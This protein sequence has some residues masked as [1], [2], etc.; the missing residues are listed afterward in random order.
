AL[1]LGQLVGRT[2]GL[3]IQQQ[4]NVN[5][6]QTPSG[7]GSLTELQQAVRLLVGGPRQP[8]DVTPVARDNG[9]AEEPMPPDDE[10]AGDED[11]DLPDAPDA[12]GQ[13]FPAEEPPPLD[14]D[15][16]LDV[17]RT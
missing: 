3:T 6:A 11:D 17:S 9:E 10:P 1:E 2:A 13:V 4:V 15:R 14:P 7:L 16:A 12:E 5:Q 8:L